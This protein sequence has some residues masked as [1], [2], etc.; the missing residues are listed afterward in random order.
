MKQIE[1][2]TFGDSSMLQMVERD[3]TFPDED[4]IKLSIKSVGLNPVDY[5][6][7]GGDKRLQLVG[8]I[9]KVL[10]PKEWFAH[11][12]TF[13]RGVARDF[14]GTIDTLGKNVTGLKIG[15][16]VFGTLR[17]APGLG[18]KKGTLA[19]KI[20]VSKH[21]VYLVPD[22]V[23]FEVAGSL[24]VAGETV[25]GALRHLAISHGDVVVIS[26]ASGG[27]GSLAVQL[28]I[29]KGAQVYG[30]VGKGN[31]DYIRS[32][33][34]IPVPYGEN[35]EQRIREITHKPIT[36][37]LDCYG[38]DYVKLAFNLGLKG[39]DIGTLVPSPQ[40]IIRG[41]QF[42]GS[43]HAQ[44]GDLQEIMH[45]VEDGTIKINIAHI[46]PFD[47][48][49]IRLAYSELSKGHTRGKLVVEML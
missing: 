4:E 12:S 35:L 37:F 16:S 39:K 31:I 36:K 42:T 5:K 34:A 26:G 8:Y 17:S 47:I 15:D 24:G 21:E 2:E 45:L 30:I 23:S 9:R 49:E 32:F 6:I 20:I 11:A 22:K 48:D 38:G 44:A 29:S 46:Y 1:Y 13:P 27:V 40:A 28:A 14:S 25:C 33:G 7:F 43:R 41:A 10:N 18:T 3:E 19:E